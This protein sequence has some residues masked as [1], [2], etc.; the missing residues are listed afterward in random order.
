MNE[1][2]K[3][4]FRI[5]K[6]CIFC[7]KELPPQVQRSGEG[8]H[9]IPKSIF[10]FWRSY[11]VCEDCRKYFGDNVDQL[12]TQ[13]PLIIDSMKQLNLG[14]PE[15]YY[16]QLN[17]IGKDIH[18]NQ[19]VKMIRRNRNYKSK[20]IISEKYIECSER[21]FD[22][23]VIKNF[24]MTLSSTYNSEELEQKLTEIKEA[25]FKLNIGGSIIDPVLGEIKRRQISNVEYDQENL[26][27]ITP[28]IAKIIF[29]AVHYFIK[30]SLLSNFIL[31]DEFRNHSRFNSKIPDY[32]INPCII[33]KSA[34]RYPFH[35]IRFLPGG[36]T[37]IIDVLFFGYV[38]W[39]SVLPFSVSVEL[40]DGIEPVEKFS[41]YL[42]FSDL[43]N[44]KKYL[45]FHYPDGRYKEIEFE[46]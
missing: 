23:L 36:C 8:E 34:K 16:E 7:S 1:E 15:K 45:T 40:D 38:N 37:L 32:T 22:Q 21:D 41:F 25:Y 26:P 31:Y 29:T 20:T 10:G 27:S 24:R 43:S 6:Y 44:R 14:N 3:N 2:S 11:D 9:V 39:R 33:R 18:S 5:Y 4:L 35:C 28:L 30:P 17:F 42:D 13:N 46:G 12:A 19:P